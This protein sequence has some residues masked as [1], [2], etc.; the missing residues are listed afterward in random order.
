L[1]FPRSDFYLR[2]LKITAIVAHTVIPAK[3]GIQK[4]EP[5]SPL[6]RGRRL[7]KFD[8]SRKS[9]REGCSQI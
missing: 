9:L 1:L 6:S 8:R 5:G 3:A 4:E 7:L 2:L